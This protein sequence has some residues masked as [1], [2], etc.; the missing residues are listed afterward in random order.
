MKCPYCNTDLDM[1]VCITGGERTL[2]VKGDI[3]ACAYCQGLFIFIDGDSARQA[4][5]IEEFAAWNNDTMARLLE[6]F[7]VGGPNQEGVRFR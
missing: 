5:P 1:H 7:Q 4:T 3:G 6:A 2:P